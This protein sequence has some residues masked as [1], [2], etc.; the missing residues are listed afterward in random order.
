MGPATSIALSLAAS[1]PSTGRTSYAT[2]SG[3]RTTSSLSLQVELRLADAGDEDDLVA[4]NRGVEW[5]NVDE[6]LCVPGCF[7]RAGC[8]LGF[9]HTLLLTFLLL[10]PSHRSLPSLFFLSLFPS[11]NLLLFFL[12]FSRSL[13]SSF[14]RDIG[15]KYTRLVRQAC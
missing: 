1:C 11:H 5:P 7:L 6:A 10:C 15:R 13:Y 14:V 2:I 12:L 8:F 4:S 3:R 9:L